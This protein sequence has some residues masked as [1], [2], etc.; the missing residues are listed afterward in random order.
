L[1]VET[2]G[3]PAVFNLILKFSMG[4]LQQMTRVYK[5]RIKNMVGVN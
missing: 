1:K 2:A 4:S 5:G 3:K